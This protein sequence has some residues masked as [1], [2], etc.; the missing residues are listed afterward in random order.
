MRVFKY[1]FAVWAAVVVYSVVSFFNGPSGL[2]AYNYLLSEKENQLENIENLTVINEEL[3]KTRS[4]LLY[5]HDTLLVYARQMGY[6]YDDEKLV[7]IVGLGGK[8]NAQAITGNVYYA[9]KPDFIADK[10]VKI[11]ALCV[12]LLIFAFFLTLEFIEIRSKEY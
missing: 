4:S 11:T 8:K 3:D 6:G 9:R 10:S 7:R 1:L 2:S 5:D 12:G